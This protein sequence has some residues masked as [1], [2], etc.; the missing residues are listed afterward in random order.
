VGGGILTSAIDIVVLEIVAHFDPI[1]G[2]VRCVVSGRTMVRRWSIEE[3]L[4]LCATSRSITSLLNRY[5]RGVI[6]KKLANRQQM[7]DD[8]RGR[9]GGR[10]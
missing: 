2:T 4:R 10:R 9:Q 8:A 1:G 7:N 5:N 3:Y 6:E